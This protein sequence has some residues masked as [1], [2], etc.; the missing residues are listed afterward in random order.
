MKT[1]L[2]ATGIIIGILA[3][4]LAWMIIVDKWKWRKIVKK[5]GERSVFE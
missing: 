4:N 5:Q 1:G 2:I 3:A